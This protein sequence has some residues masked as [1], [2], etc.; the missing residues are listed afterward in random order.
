MSQVEIWQARKSPH[1][2]VT[3]AALVPTDTIDEHIT[4][5]KQ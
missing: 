1:L 5:H 2:V 3:K 4:Y